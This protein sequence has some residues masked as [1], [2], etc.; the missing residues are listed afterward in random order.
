VGTYLT[1]DDDDWNKVIAEANKREPRRIIHDKM[2]ALIRR[3][4]RPHGAAET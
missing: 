3:R 4:G 2:L 1:P